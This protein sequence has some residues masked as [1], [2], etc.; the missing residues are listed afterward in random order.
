[1]FTRI[2][3][4]A[5]ALALLTLISLSGCFSTRSSQP[6]ESFHPKY[7][8]GN[9]AAI[10]RLPAT[11]RRVVVLPAYWEADPN[12]GFVNDLD[13]IL[14]LSLQRTNA[15]EVVPVTR[16]QLHKLFGPRQFS[17][18]A[19]LP[20]NLLTVLRDKYAADAVLF[21]DLTVNRPYHPISLGLRTKLVRVDDGGIIWAVDALF[22]SADPAVARAA[23]D[24]SR[25][26]TYNRYPV[27][28]SGGIL[29]SPR[30]FAGFAAE[31]LFD[32][33]PSR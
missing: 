1:M 32:T 33:L 9:V 22:D 16:M 17:S 30:A 21:I 14:H 15:F 13:A 3:S 4:L 24:F 2:S 26:S 5:L 7:K 8:P 27:D 19:V 25:R 20:D 18:V 11:V 12:S 23:L 29:Q 6:R 10:P 31:T 28:S